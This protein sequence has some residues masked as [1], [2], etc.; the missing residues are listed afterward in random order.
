MS[1]IINSLLS[2]SGGLAYAVV[3]LLAFGEAAAFVGLFLP[4][5]T[6]LLVGGVLAANGRVSLPV[7]LVVAAVAAVAGDSVGYEIG[8][9]FGPPLRRSRLGRLVGEQRWSR[10]EAYVLRRGGPAVL[11]G[12]WVG[13]LRALVPALAGMTRMPYRRFLAWNAAGGVAWASTVVLVGYAAG[14]AWQTFAGYLGRAGT[15]LLALAL[16]VLIARWLRRR[17]NPRTLPGEPEGEHRA[18]PQPG[19]VQTERART[20]AGR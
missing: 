2:L 19:P 20:G 6:A 12:R 13:V 3:G 11:L 4:G 8:R 1:G 18:A 5:E 15:V 17:R 10:A 9:H 7:L 14:A 16:L